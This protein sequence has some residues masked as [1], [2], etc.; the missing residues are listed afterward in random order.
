MAYKYLKANDAISG[1]E[2]MA[3]I[4]LNDRKREVAEIKSLEATIEKNKSEFKALGY[5]GTQ[6]K[7]QGWSG[8]G[9]V[10][11][12]FIS[13]EW[14]EMM[15][16]YVETGKDVYFDMI[17]ENNDPSSN[18]GVQRIQL[19]DCN[20]NSI[21]IAKLDVDADNLEQDFD[22]TFSDVKLLDS[23]KPLG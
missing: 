11:L 16:Q 1:K 9:S 22:F 14:V 2:G 23:F 17:V 13:S 15:L 19:M 10:T 8:S 7:A 6:H 20:I 3:Y 5:R 12:Y 21:Q 18:A 4:T